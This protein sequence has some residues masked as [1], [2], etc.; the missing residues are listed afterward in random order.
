MESVTWKFVGYSRALKGFVL[1]FPLSLG[2]NCGYGQVLFF[3]LT[4]GSSVT[5]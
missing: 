3:Y 2:K 4:C 1:F 5:H